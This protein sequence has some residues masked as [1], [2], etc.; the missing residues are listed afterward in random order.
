MPVN[1]S[2]SV[3][4][5]EYGEVLSPTYAVPDPDR[6]GEW[7]IL[8]KNVEAHTGLDSAS[9]GGEGQ[10]HASPQLRF[11]RMLRETGVPIGC[12]AMPPKS[13][14]SM[15]RARSPPGISRSR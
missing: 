12:S 1:D 5:P 7:L 9:H 3:S 8:I 13:G 10:W 11:E 6:P 2:L 15:L 14:W 4:L